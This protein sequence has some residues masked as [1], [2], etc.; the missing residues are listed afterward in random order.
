MTGGSGPTGG[1]TPKWLPYAL[2][3]TGILGA[4]LER[5]RAALSKQSEAEQEDPDGVKEACE[6]AGKLLEDWEPEE[7]WDVE[8]DFR[9][10]LADYL[11]EQS[12]WE[13]KV[14]P[15]TEVGQ[16]DIL[17]GDLLALEVKLNPSKAERDR[18][19]GQCANYAKKW[20]T[21]VILITEREE[22]QEEME[23][24]LGSAG[25]DRV[26]VHA[27]VAQEEEQE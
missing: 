25:L 27:W 4:W 15:V 7:E 18:C 24:Q 3:G 5:Q 2:I 22:D 11:G 1:K 16:P 9:D 19:V 26:V 10:D 17:I 21:W 6:E 12:E 14:A 13:I 8:D 23:K 20:A